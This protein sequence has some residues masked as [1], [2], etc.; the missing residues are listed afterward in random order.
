MGST[1]VQYLGTWIRKQIKGKLITFVAQK[2][3]PAEIVLASL[4]TCCFCRLCPSHAAAACSGPFPYSYSTSLL[5]WQIFQRSN[6]ERASR[7]RASEL[8]WSDGHAAEELDVGRARS[9]TGRRPA[10]ML[11]MCWFLAQWYLFIRSTML[12]SLH[13]T[14]GTAEKIRGNKAIKE[15]HRWGNPRRSRIC[16]PEV[17]IQRPRSR[18]LGSINIS[19]I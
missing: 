14:G 18:F 3:A 5:L 7:T 13:H 11:T 6:R 2:E 17:H 19:P 10:L 8:T 1:V 4:A 9:C 12:Q 15:R 16:P